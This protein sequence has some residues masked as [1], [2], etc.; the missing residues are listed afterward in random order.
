MISTYLLSLNILV[1]LAVSSV[2]ST[3]N[4]RSVVVLFCCS[5]EIKNINE[6]LVI[7]IYIIL[8]DNYEVWSNWNVIME[9]KFN[10][11]HGILVRVSVLL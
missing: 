10:L 11:V 8:I 6:I 7:I 1:A 4:V 9:N 3:E 2:S 5:L